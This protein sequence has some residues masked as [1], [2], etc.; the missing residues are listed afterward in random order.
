[1]A[2][3]RSRRWPLEARLKAGSRRPTFDRYIDIGWIDVESTEA[4]PGPLGCHERGP[5]AQKEVQ[6]EVAVP[7]HVQ[8]RIGDQSRRLDRRM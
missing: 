2:P 1:M 4:P 7:G 5:R 3:L 8:D 6:H